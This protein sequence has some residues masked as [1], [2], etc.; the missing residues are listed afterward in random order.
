ML[1][2]MHLSSINSNLETETNMIATMNSIGDFIASNEHD[3]T[4]RVASEFD[5]GFIGETL[6]NDD[7]EVEKKTTTKRKPG[8]L[9]LSDVPEDSD[10]DDDDD[11]EASLISTG[12]NSSR[13]RGRSRGKSLRQTLENTKDT[14]RSKSPSFLRR[15]RCFDDNSSV[16]SIISRASLKSF[17]KRDDYLDGDAQEEEAFSSHEIEPT[18]MEHDFFANFSNSQLTD[19]IFEGSDGESSHYSQFKPSL[20]RARSAESASSVSSKKIKKSKGKHKSSSS[21]DKREKSPKHERREKSPKREKAS[22]KKE[23]QTQETRDP[24]V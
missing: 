23:K 17:H 20:M 22:K 10:I 21:K 16:G 18:E 3:Q 24:E 2:T 12:T 8:N 11:D 19:D 4:F 9:L 7:E 14:I 13:G 1:Q 6:L 15:R 5:E